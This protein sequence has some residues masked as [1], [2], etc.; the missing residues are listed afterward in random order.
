MLL[1]KNGLGSL[2]YNSS[3]K[4]AKRCSRKDSPSSVYQD[5]LNISFDKEFPPIVFGYL[6]CFVFGTLAV[7]WG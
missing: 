4:F 2:F 7:N 1:D 3:P 6:I 5:T